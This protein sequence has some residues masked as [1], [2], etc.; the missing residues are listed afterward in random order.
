MRLKPRENQDVNKW[1]MCDDGRYGYKSIDEN[2]ILDVRVKNGEK[3]NWNVALQVA[4]Q[5]LKNA[6]ASSWALLASAQ[7]TNEDL[8][9]KKR[10]FADHLKWKN[11]AFSAPGQDGFEDDFLIKKDKNPNTAG[12]SEILKL[13]GT[14]ADLTAVIEK[15]K[16]GDLEGLFIFGH[17]LAK[18]FGPDALKLIR[19]KVKT[20]IYEG[21]NENP[22]AAVADLVLPSACYAEKEGT[23]TNFE[24]RVQ[25]V[26]KAIEPIAASRPTVEILQEL[27]GLLGLKLSYDRP[28]FI[29]DELAKENNMFRGLDYKKI[30]KQGVIGSRCS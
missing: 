8:Y 28:E 3:S 4:A 9:L 25:R 29:F 24:G 13:S 23:F 30:G 6:N 27:S 15:A 20:I 2:R 5:A 11:I 21:S 22:T 10:L 18:L 7:Y 12:A 1:W 14:A 17:D 16:R 19:Q 26:R